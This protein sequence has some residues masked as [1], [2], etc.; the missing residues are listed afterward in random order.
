MTM[1]Q[2]NK[3]RVLFCRCLAL[4]ALPGLFVP[5]AHALSD[6]Q[7]RRMLKTSPAYAQ[8]EAELGQAWKAL[9]EALAQAGLKDRFDG[10]TNPPARGSVLA[11]QREWLRSGRDREAKALRGGGSEADGYAEATRRRAASLRKQ[12]ET[13]IASAGAAANRAP[14]F[15]AGTRHAAYL[16]AARAF[17][18]K[19][20]MPDGSDISADLFADADFAGNSLAIRD[21]DGDGRPELLVKLETAPM[22]GMRES[23]FGLD[24]NT[25]RFVEKLSGFPGIE[26][27]NN[28]CAREG[29]SHN[30]GLAGDH[31]WPFT[32]HRLNVKTGTYES[33]GFVD[34][35]SEK[36]YPTDREDKP[37]PKQIDAVGDGYVYFLHTDPDADF[38]DVKPVDT[39]VYKAWIGSFLDG[40]VPVRV[41]W[42]PANEKGLEDLQRQE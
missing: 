39:P 26:Y 32:L 30:Q 40:A 24:E 33:M 36:E 14:N 15:P 6:A 31:F 16:E 10:G 12:A 27:F 18:E 21:V 29:A 9:R 35:W 17:V 25:G 41:D 13:L 37:F 4:W 5:S 34:A 3:V 8:A 42:V 2:Y 7:Y 20:R 38:W 1:K 19:H 28:G 22:A 11:E 23:V